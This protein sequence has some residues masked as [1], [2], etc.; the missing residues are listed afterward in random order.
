MFST[1]QDLHQQTQTP[2]ENGF[3]IDKEFNRP[4][5]LIADEA[6]HLNAVTK[7][8]TKN[9]TSTDSDLG[10]SWEDTIQ[11]IHKAN[12]KNILL[13]F[14]ATMDLH[15]SG[16]FDKYIDKLII[17]Y[18]LREFR[19]DGYSKEVS[20]EI[21]D[22]KSVLD[23]A[24]HAVLL[25]QYRKRLLLKYKIGNKPVIL[26]KSKTIEESRRFQKDFEAFIR[27]LDSETL[28]KYLTDQKSSLSGLIELLQ[29]E[30]ANLEQFLLEIKEDFAESRHLVVNS[31]DESEIKQL[32]LNSLEEPTNL[33]RCI[34]AVDKLNE[35]WDVL[36]LFDIV[37]LY[38]TRDPTGNT[39]F[40]QSKIGATTMSEA[41]LIGRGARYFAF[42]H[43]QD[44]DKFKRKFDDDIS[45]E[46]R[47]CETLSYHSANN[48][49]YIQELN[50][51]L[52]EIGI[53]SKSSVTRL[54]ELKDSFRQSNLYATGYILLNEREKRTSDNSPAFLDYAAKSYD[55]KLS[56]G[57]SRSLNIFNE[58]EL[59]PR[60]ATKT[61]T[62]SVSDLDYEL[63][64]FCVSAEPYFSLDN[65]KS[66]FPALTGLR[67]FITSDAYLNSL[68]IT[69]V[70]PFESL[71]QLDLDALIMILGEV[72]TRI[73]EKLSTSKLEYFGTKNFKPYPLSKILRDKEMNFNID[74]DSK[75]EMGKSMNDPANTYH[76]DLRTKQW[77]VYNDC[78][79]TSEEKL[80]VKYIDR[81][82]AELSSIYSDV[83]LVRNERFFKIYDFKS[84]Q[85]TEP[86]FLLLLSK[87]HAKHIE[88]FQVFIEPKGQHLYLLDKWKQDLL[89]SLKDEAIA[90]LFVDSEEVRIWGLPFYQNAS[91]FEFDEAFAEA[92]LN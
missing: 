78:Y 67:E 18:P 65:I 86:D 72:L 91:E 49:K 48:P 80:L 13:D 77:Y 57:E 40:G 32:A 47:L 84:G 27:E 4:L 41:Q 20:V 39:G 79:G 76:L 87:K 26:F 61:F 6:H 75:E 37:R 64:R 23:R 60:I 28:K 50:S 43:G 52:H 35:G 82:Y 45:H 90:E 69:L 19:R 58:E 56:S 55:I 33:F 30:S 88:Q 63:K 31:K 16:V 11:A 85:A 9:S 62:I 10:S 5:I 2:R 36:N 42:N 7:K 34:F 73:A 17:D 89:L 22:S 24:I 25:S 1:I 74:V 46:L 8:S 38:D 29:N 59:F 3:T 51:A 12:P 83:Y 68:K 15:N 44:L 14:T 92:L 81:K 70:S 53:K 54:F 66:L 21:F 71:E